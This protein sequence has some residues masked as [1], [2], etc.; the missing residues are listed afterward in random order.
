AGEVGGR[1]IGTPVDRARGQ[2][3]AGIFLPHLYVKLLY[4][5]GDAFATPIAPK[6]VGV[7]GD[8]AAAMDGVEAGDADRVVAVHFAVRRL[9]ISDVVEVYTVD[10]VVLHAIQ[11]DRDVVVHHVGMT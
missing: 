5:E 10:V 4:G 1:I 11:D 7:G 2:H 9:G 8:A 3:D 6:L